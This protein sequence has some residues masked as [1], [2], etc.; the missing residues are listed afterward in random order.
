MREQ[1][2]HYA[3]RAEALSE[4]ADALGECSSAAWLRRC[5]DVRRP[6]FA[7]TRCWSSFALFADA[8][9]RRDALAAATVA[10]LSGDR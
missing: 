5:W 7:V 9:S 1:G 3:A 10:A 2:T 4:V 8:V 6:H